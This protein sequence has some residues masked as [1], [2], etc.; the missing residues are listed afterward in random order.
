MAP[1]QDSDEEANLKV[2]KKLAFAYV[3]M[4]TRKVGPDDPKRS[5]GK[6]MKNRRE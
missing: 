5:W 4:Y 6:G 2:M 1:T 3:R